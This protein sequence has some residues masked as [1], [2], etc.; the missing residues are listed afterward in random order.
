VLS[1][2]NNVNLPNLSEGRRGK[3]RYPWDGMQHGDSFVIPL[4]DREAVGTSFRVW[5]QRSPARAQ[6]TYVSR[7]IG[8]QQVRVWLYDP[9]VI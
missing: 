8:P 6:L 5:K 1:I 9:D 4:R 7:T 3:K 2:D